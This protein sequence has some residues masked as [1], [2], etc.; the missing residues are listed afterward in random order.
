[1]SRRLRESG[2]K[3]V[4]KGHT[5]NLQIIESKCQLWFTAV[6]ERA[7]ALEIDSLD[8]SEGENQDCQPRASPYVV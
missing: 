2:V 5:G 4:D 6:I 8:S 3:S 1:M 7:S